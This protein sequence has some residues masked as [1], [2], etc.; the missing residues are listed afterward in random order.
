MK[1]KRSKREILI[2]NWIIDSISAEKRVEIITIRGKGARH[3]MD[4]AFKLYPGLRQ[5][6]S[7]KL[8]EFLGTAPETIRRNRKYF[9]KNNERELR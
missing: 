3:K 2:E 8:A 6:R 7:E 9:R 5:I 1:K 4:Y